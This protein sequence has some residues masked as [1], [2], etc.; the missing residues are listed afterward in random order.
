MVEWI[1]VK[2][3]RE[4]VKEARAEIAT[5]RT[6]PQLVQTLSRV[7]TPNLPQK[8]RPRNRLRWRAKLLWIFDRFLGLRPF[9][10]ISRKPKHCLYEKTLSTLTKLIY[11]PTILVNIKITP[12]YREK[13]TL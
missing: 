3:S 4:G 5:S 12:N 9:G 8:L 13:P 7:G 1:V 6:V 11:P 2:E 10:E